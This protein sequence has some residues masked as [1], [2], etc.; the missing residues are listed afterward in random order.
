MEDTDLALL[1]RVEN[2]D[3]YVHQ[4]IATMSYELENKVE[5]FDRELNNN[6]ERFNIDII[7]LDDEIKFLDDEIKFLYDEKNN[8]VRYFTPKMFGAVGDGVADDTDALRAAIYESHIT[9]IVLFFPNDCK[10]RVSGPLNYYNGEYYSPVLNMRGV[11]PTGKWEYSL[12][13][14]GGVTVRNNTNIFQG[15]TIT[16]EI[17]NISFTGIR[18]E[19]LHFFD[20]C[21][22]S[23]IY[24]HGCN[25]TNFGAFLYDTGLSGVSRIDRNTFLT[26]FYFHRYGGKA[27][28]ITDSY[29]TNNYIN[30][31]AE[32]TNNACF[33]FQNGNGS[34]IQGNFIDYYKV[35]YRPKPQATV[36]FPASIGNQYQVFLYLYEVTDGSSFKFSSVNDTFN[37]TDET[38]LEKLRTYE[39]STYTGG[40]GLTYEIPSHI[41]SVRYSSTVTFKNAYIQSNVSTVIFYKTHY[42]E[43]SYFNYDLDFAGVSK[44]DK[45]VELLKGA[46]A[47]YYIGGSYSYNTCDSWFI[48]SVDA[49]P[50]IST[51]WNSRPIGY[52]VRYESQDYK[53]IYKKDPSSGNRT[54]Q[55]VPI[56]EG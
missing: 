8:Q 21:L 11:L 15:A 16:G 14:Y 46:N 53:L 18:N 9:G 5:E 7:R 29:I 3:Q 39:K 31:G 42:G 48:E 17:S 41:V 20:N 55:W 25:I 37:W 51:P 49:L 43:Y 2:V 28:S 19:D 34:T 12:S 35:I 10:C 27:T 13:K 38:K 6:I 47:P 23:S 40:D 24:I 30:G 45:K 50:Q 32:P 33:E 22:L 56:D 26:N 52:K 44:R 54:L 1:N 4:E 36:E